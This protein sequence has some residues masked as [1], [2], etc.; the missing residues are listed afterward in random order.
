MLI[1]EWLLGI[2]TVYFNLLSHNS[3]EDSRETTK[4]LGY[5]IRFE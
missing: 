1:C 2:D 3:P 4:N 5:D